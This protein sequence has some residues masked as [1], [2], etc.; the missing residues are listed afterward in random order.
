MGNDIKPIAV[1][2]I[3]EKF[4]NFLSESLKHIDQPAI[5]DVGAGHGALSKTLY[6]AGFKVSACELFP[7]LFQFEKVECKQADITKN[8]PYPDDSFD[9]LIAVEV[10]EHIHDHEH[11]LQECHRVLKNNGFLFFST[12]NIL[13]LKSRM[14]F[15][16][17]GFV[18]SFG[19]LDHT[20]HDGMQHV[21]SLTVDQY[22]NLA[23]RNGFRMES[24]TIDKK[25]NSSKALIFLIPFIKLYCWLKPVDFKVH[26]Q[27]KF[28]TGRKLFV[29]LFKI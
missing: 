14:R 10:M 17:S 5:L 16:F 28:L 26:N 11:F 6:D 8:L 21:A 19:P 13:S 23:V 25:Q 24:I 12:P 20:R 15:L 27:Y 1:A 3:H 9:A 7:E 22:R 4:F 29:R 18:Y 2:G